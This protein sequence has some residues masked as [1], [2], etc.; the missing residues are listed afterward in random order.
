[1]IYRKFGN[2]GETISAIGFGCMRLP[3]IE[4]D[5]VWSVDQEKVN[6]M[7]RY[8][9]EHGINYFD[10]APY[11]C[12]HNSEA[13]VGEG[14]RPFRDKVL[15]ST[16]LPTGDVKT[17]ADTWTFL[18]QS[19]SRLQTDHID[20]YH[21]WATNWQEFSGHVVKDG[22]L[23]EL[24]KAKE[25][26]KIRHICFSFHDKHENIRRII[27]L[28]ESEG[29]PMETM[30][31]QYNMLDRGVEDMLKFA[32]GEKGLGTVAMGPVGGG[33]LAARTK[34]TDALA[35]D[36]GLTSYELAFRFVLGNPYMCCA[37]SGMQNI[38]MVKQNCAIAESERPLSEE[39]WRMLGESVEKLRRFSE[40][41]CTG[42]GYCQ[43]CPVGINIPYIFDQ[44]TH[45]NVYGLPE[46]AKNGYKHYIEKDNGKTFADCVGC[47]KCEAACPQK[48]P[49]REKLE[50]VDKAL[51]A[52]WEE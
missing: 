42:C 36:T 15:L 44:Y 1:M 25:Q 29:V 9:Y 37:L 12:H 16:K 49:I 3:E 48:L 28:A 4:K 43:P 2:T 32:N 10:T 18:E 5:G 26:G 52:L 51:R 7:F 19:L 11:Y 24:K 14:V 35:G 45:Y 8:A 23:A 20:F 30:L 33:R 38:D 22:I 46:N 50:T 21:V 31:V 27:E 41:Y 40:L 6:E 39:E 47:G 17:A 34:F 13:A